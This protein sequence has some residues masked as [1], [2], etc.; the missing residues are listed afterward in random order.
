MSDKERDKNAI[1]CDLKNNLIINEPDLFTGTSHIDGTYYHDSDILKYIGLE[2]Y[3]MLLRKF[4]SYF[5]YFDEFSAY[6]NSDELYIPGYIN[7]YISDD[8]RT[9]KSEIIKTI[10]YKQY[11]FKN[12]F[13][14]NKEEENIELKEKNNT[15]FIWIFICIII[16]S[17]IFISIYVLNYNYLLTNRLKGSYVFIKT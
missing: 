16:V 1:L 2:N 15:V 7:L 11:F 10:H 13:L 17:L 9:V 8:P 4:P 5:I 14:V 3:I 6:F 12:S